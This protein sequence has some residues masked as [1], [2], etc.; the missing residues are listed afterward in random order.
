MSGLKDTSFYKMAAPSTMIQKPSLS[1]SFLTSHRSSN[2]AYIQTGGRQE[3]G[4]ERIKEKLPAR[5]IAV[6][7]MYGYH[8]KEDNDDWIFDLDGMARVQILLPRCLFV[9]PFSRVVTT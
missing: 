3:K 6:A 5:K 9:Y 2:G 8:L 1:E 4:Q 7:H